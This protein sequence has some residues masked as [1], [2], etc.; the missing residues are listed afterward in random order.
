[1][2]WTVPQWWI[3]FLGACASFVLSL[4]SIAWTWKQS[5]RVDDE[6]RKDRELDEAARTLID[7]LKGLGDF[8]ASRK[9]LWPIPRESWEAAQRAQEWGAIFVRWDSGQMQ[10]RVKVWHDQIEPE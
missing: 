6:L 2:N 1:M 9:K 10:G 4:V 8:N 7:G 3:L 5:K